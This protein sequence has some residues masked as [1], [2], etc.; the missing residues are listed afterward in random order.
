LE[1]HKRFVNKASDW[2]IRK[3]EANQI[4]WATGLVLPPFRIVQLEALFTNLLW[5]SNCNLF[6]SVANCSERSAYQNCNIV[7]LA[8]LQYCSQENIRFDCK[9]DDSYH[10]IKV[11]KACF[12]HL[13]N[14]RRIKKYL[15][16]DNLL[17]LVHAFITS[18]LDYCNSLFYGLP[19]KRISKLQRVQNAAAR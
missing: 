9:H 17:I 6:A 12:F 10:K 15:S 14:I 7:G 5:I 8:I 13:H 1:I 3:R 2:I 19:G 11:C 18:R 16:R 4:V